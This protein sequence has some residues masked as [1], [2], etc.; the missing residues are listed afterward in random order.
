ML[1]TVFMLILAVNAVAE[2]AEDFAANDITLG[3]EATIEKD[4]SGKHLIISDPKNKLEFIIN[5]DR[6]ILIKAAD[7]RDN[8]SYSEIRLG[9]NEDDKNATTIR[10]QQRNI[11]YETIKEVFLK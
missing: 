1:R 6:V 11:P 4:A 9:L 3:T 2:G 8:N 7:S 10:I 5:V